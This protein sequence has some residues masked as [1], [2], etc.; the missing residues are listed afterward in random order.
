[1]VF[2]H[3]RSVAFTTSYI[4]CTA[5]EC[6]CGGV[7][8]GG[9]GGEKGLWRKGEVGGRMAGIRGDG[10]SWYSPVDKVCC[11]NCF[12]LANVLRPKESDTTLL[13][14]YSVHG[15]AYNYTIV[16]CTCYYKQ[17]DNLKIGKRNLKIAQI[18]KLRGTHNVTYSGL[19]CKCHDRLLFDS[20]YMEH[21]H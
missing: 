2:E 13:Y 8:G 4:T 6:V 11:H 10:T 16:T 7:G 18:Y 3:W 15:I 12:R 19:S 1:M 21:K 17:F 14:T 20:R 9:G 5:I